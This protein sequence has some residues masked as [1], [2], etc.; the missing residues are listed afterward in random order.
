VNVEEAIP[1]YG[2]MD[3]ESQTHYVGLYLLACYP[4]L[5]RAQGATENQ[6][7]DAA[8]LPQNIS[9]LQALVYFIFQFNLSHDVFKKGIRDVIKSV[10]PVTWQ[11]TTGMRMMMADGYY[12]PLLQCLSPFEAH[13]PSYFII[14][15]LCIALIR[16]AIRLETENYSLLI[17][18]LTAFLDNNY[19]QD[20]L[21][22][23]K[24]RADS[25]ENPW[26]LRYLPDPRHFMT[27]NTDSGINKVRSDLLGSVV[28]RGMFLAPQL[29][30]NNQSAQAP[31]ANRSIF[32]ICRVS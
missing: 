23:V 17:R 8:K 28:E 15:M 18:L 20:I 14:L 29:G 1:G 25:L 31:T 9:D 11:M 32:D 12:A 7:I 5:L 27:E 2:G 4:H 6:G 24:T 21:N 19:N 16:T 22:T 26:L 3:S 10:T 13:L 30:K